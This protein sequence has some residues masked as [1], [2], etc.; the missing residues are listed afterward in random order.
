MNRKL[1]VGAVIALIAIAFTWTIE[2][3]RLFQFG[4]VGS[5]AIAMLGLN[6][7]TGYN[8]QI[9]L[10]HGTFFGVGAYTVAIAVRDLGLSYPL[11]FVLA[12]IVCFVIGGLI[13][14]PALR[15]PGISLA[16]I[17]LAMAL[18]FPQ[19][20]R[21][22]G[23]LTGGVQGINTSPD[24]QLNAP[25]WT[26]L[27]NDQFRYLVVVLVGTLMFW[28]A[29]NLTRSRWGL[30]MMSIRDNPLSAVSMGVNQSSTKI[31]AF[32]ISAGYAGLGG[33]LFSM[34]FGFIAPESVTL[35]VSISLVAGMVIGGLGT[36]AGAVIGGFFYV[37]MPNFATEVSDQA[38]GVVYGVIIVAVMVLAPGGVMG[39]GRQG[40]NAL[41][42]WLPAFKRPVDQPGDVGDD[43]PVEP[44][45]T[46]HMLSKG[47]SQ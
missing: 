1:L 21:K 25:D 23:G 12:F 6:M 13:G 9:S 32:A 20:L 18:A 34:I 28:I 36:V 47:E 14:I 37:F 33:A 10:G 45:A 29:W 35:F 27:S 43:Q 26:N 3:Y 46:T 7:L 42:R 41:R 19:F 17:T 8:G 30:A 40:A 16:L 5:W 39:L 31:I 11:T 38:P 24:R 15:L 4:Q 2:D 22:F 44:A